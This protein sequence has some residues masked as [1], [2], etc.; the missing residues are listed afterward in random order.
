M[1]TIEITKEAF[2]AIVPNEQECFKHNEKLELA[3]RTHFY[4]KGMNLIT[5]FNF[6]SNVKQYYLTDINA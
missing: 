4:S 2:N 6:I 3:E 5:V 1:T